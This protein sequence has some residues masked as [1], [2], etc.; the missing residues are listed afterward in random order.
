L[1]A[2]AWGFPEKAKEERTP[3]ANQQVLGLDVSGVEEAMRLGEEVVF[4]ESR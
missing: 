4:L 2:E 1:N 3:M